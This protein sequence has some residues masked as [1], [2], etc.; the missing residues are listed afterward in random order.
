MN[1][2]VREGRV[3]MDPIRQRGTERKSGRSESRGSDAGSRT[4]E[5]LLMQCYMAA[6]TF[7]ATS[8]GIH[9]VH[10]LA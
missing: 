9:F 2:M 10:T 4:P 3:G 8:A 1:P 7:A 5:P 6:F